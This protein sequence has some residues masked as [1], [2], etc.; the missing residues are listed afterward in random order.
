[1]TVAE[2]ATRI[3]AWADNRRLPHAPLARW[4]ALG[5]EDSAALLGLAEDLRL[6]TGQL[7]TALEMLEEIAL[8]DRASVAAVLARHEIRRILNGTGSAPGRARALLD[9][10]RAF[11]FPRLKRTADRLTAAIAALGLPRG[12]A[13]VLPRALGSDELRIEISAHGGAKLDRL[14][15]ALANKRAGLR[16]IADLLGG[17]DEV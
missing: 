10:L 5:P 12:V 13:V 6:R 2:T 4:L 14:L 11:R 15:E 3:R 16:R 8:R 1:M 7:I 17:I 9:Q